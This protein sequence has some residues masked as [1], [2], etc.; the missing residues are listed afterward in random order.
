M[1]SIENNNYA[2]KTNFGVTIIIMTEL[3]LTNTG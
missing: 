3:T 2:N 1:F